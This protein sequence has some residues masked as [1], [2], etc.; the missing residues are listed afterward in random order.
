MEFSEEEVM[1]D[2]ERESF[3]TLTKIGIVNARSVFEFGD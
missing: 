1:S 2:S 3:E